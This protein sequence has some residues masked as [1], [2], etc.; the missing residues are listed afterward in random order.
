M[1]YT[2]I[3]KK[4]ICYSYYSV[5]ALLQMDGFTT[6]LVLF[7]NEKYISSWRG[8]FFPCGDK[9]KKTSGWGTL[10]CKRIKQQ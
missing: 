4:S 7:V 10:C 6:W 2:Q 3:L 8:T 9:A 1:W 5:V